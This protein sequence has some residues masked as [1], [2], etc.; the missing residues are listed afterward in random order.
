MLVA[1]GI[2]IGI[3]FAIEIAVDGHLNIDADS[4][5][6]IDLDAAVW[7]YQPYCR[8]RDQLRAISIPGNK[9]LILH[10]RLALFLR[11]S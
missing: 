5:L 7:Q 3:A 2:G 9:P 8:D 10:Q 11:F 4:D 1:V 6:D